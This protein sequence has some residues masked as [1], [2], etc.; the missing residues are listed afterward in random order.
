MGELPP[1][2]PL[3][4]AEHM[5]KGFPS[6][7][8]WRATFSLRQAALKDPQTGAVCTHDEIIQ[9]IDEMLVACEKWLPQYVENGAMEEAKKRL[10]NKTVPY[11]ETKGF[12]LKK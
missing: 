1:A 8:R 10:E 2:A 12:K 9:M 7:R 3:S 5:G 4:V 6:R 11:R